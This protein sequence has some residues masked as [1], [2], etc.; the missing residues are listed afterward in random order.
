[1]DRLRN[2]EM[3][4]IVVANWIERAQ[5][6]GHETELRKG[7]PEQRRHPMTIL[8]GDISE[9]RDSLQGQSTRFPPTEYKSVIKGMNPALVDR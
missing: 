4:D 9:L 5:V 7:A 8:V 6:R 2:Y 1:M 3:R